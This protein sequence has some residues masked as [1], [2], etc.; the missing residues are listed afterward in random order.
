VSNFDPIEPNL[1][2]ERIFHAD[3]FADEPPTLEEIEEQYGKK[4]HEDQEEMQTNLASEEKADKMEV[5]GTSDISAA[6]DTTQAF[7]SW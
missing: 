5:S 7:N 6:T 3:P 2:Q 1:F 4:R